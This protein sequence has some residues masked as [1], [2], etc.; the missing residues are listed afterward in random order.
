MKHIYGAIFCLLNFSFAVAANAAIVEQVCTESAVQPNQ[1]NLIEVVGSQAR[2]TFNGQVYELTMTTQPNAQGNYPE[3]ETFEST[4]KEITLQ[5]DHAPVYQQNGGVQT[6]IRT[7]AAVIQAGVS[8][9]FD[10]CQTH[11]SNQPINI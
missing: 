2:V 8:T 7:T 9:E 5:L 3:I 10:S 4:G 11:F 6:G 1:G